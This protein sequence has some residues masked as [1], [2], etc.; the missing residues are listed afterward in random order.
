MGFSRQEYWS[1]LPFPSLGDLPD[2]G[3]KPQS[4]ALQAY[5]LLSEPPGKHLSERRYCKGI[6]V[7]ALL[8]HMYLFKMGSPVNRENI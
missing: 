3:I 2:P 5:T 1:G 8:L 6:N 4:P 7:V